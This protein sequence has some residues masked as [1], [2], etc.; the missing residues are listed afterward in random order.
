M[1]DI[2][3]MAGVLALCFSNCRNLF[4]RPG[5]FGAVPQTPLSFIHYLTCHMS[6]VMC[7]VSK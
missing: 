7:Q 3:I 6:Q 4:N 1:V 2:Q 5:V